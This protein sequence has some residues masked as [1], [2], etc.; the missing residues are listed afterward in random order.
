MQS[1]D[2]KTLE[3]MQADIDAK[4]K[5]LH[6]LEFS[7]LE[8]TIIFNLLVKAEYSLANARVLLPIIDKIEPIVVAETNIEDKVEVN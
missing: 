7:K 3:E 5:E 6:T 2:E 4:S 8:L 1:K